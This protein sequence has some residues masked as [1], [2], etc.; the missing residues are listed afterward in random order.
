MIHLKKIL[1]RLIFFTALILFANYLFT[2][3]YALF[4]AK[5]GG[6][7]ETAGFAYAIYSIST[8]ILILVMGKWEDHVK[9]RE[10]LL[11]A[12]SFLSFVGF[13]AYL[14]VGDITQLFLVQIVLGIA[15]AIA[16]PAF[17]SMYSENLDKGKH[18]SEWSIWEST[19]YITAS[20]AAAAGGIIVGTF[21]FSVLFILM[22][23]LSLGALVIAITLARIKD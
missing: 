16:M 22:A 17:D 12:A 13:S 6:N 11:I 2:P 20:F 9:H 21:G 23:L 3:I 4:V 10:N 1:N 19:N 15:T 14:F 5:I 8:A 18:A 7:V